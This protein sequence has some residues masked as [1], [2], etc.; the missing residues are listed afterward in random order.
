[1]RNC[2]MVWV[3]SDCK[4]IVNYE[5]GFLEVF[6]MCYVNVLLHYIAIG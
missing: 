6:E 3:E 5:D 1:M 4:V 2:R